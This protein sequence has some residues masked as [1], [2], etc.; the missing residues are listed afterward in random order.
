MATSIWSGCHGIE[1]EPEP[2]AFFEGDAYAAEGIR[3]VP[4]TLGEA[5]EALDGSTVMRA[6][7]GDEVID[8]Y[9]HAGR[10]EQSEYD[11]HVT[12]WEVR[13]NFEQA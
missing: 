4:R 5:L 10:W 7:F 3:Q 8:H 2:E 1:Q 9:L 12:D 6:A 13:R 11:R